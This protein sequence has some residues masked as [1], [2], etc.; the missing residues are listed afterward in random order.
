[1]RSLKG[2]NECLFKKQRFVV[3]CPLNS[4]G[5]DYLKEENERMMSFSLVRV[6]TLLQIDINNCNNTIL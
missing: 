5:F 3:I 6:D 4:D 1:M 2:V